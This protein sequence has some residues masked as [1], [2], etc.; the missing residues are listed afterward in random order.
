MPASRSS[1][2]DVLK[3]LPA[4]AFA[5]TAGA[6]AAKPRIRVGQIGTQHAHAA[7]KLDSILRFPEI[8][9]VVGVVEP[10]AERRA[11][12]Q[13]QAPYAGQTWLTEEELLSTE[14]LQ[15][16]AVETEVS[17]LVPTAMRCLTAGKHIHLDK[18]A[19]E[20]LDA[21]RAMHALAA[22]RGLTIQM[23]YMLR[24]NPAFVF[25]HQVV[26]DGW[27]GEITE[28]SGMMGKLINDKGRK[29]LAGFEG[30]GMFELACH[31]IDQVVAFLG[32]PSSV[33]A[34]THRT[35]PEKDR[36][37][38]NQLAVFDYPK[39]L[40]TIRCNHIDPMGGP[41]RQFNL[42]GTHG[43]LEIRPLEPTP[44]VRLGLDQARGDFKKGWQD[45]T[46]EP[47]SGRYDAEF[48]DLAAVLRGEKKLAWDAA[49]DLATHEAVLR[50]ADM[51][52]TA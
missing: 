35:Y 44:L 26:R 36:F 39:A 15:A 17:Q 43:T 2:R 12:L 45:V 19:G 20:S 16:V 50:A 11:L 47:P 41:R 14:G 21:C 37:A 3:I 34:F 40:A 52:P 18:P 42:T 31:L 28:I 24:Y 51:H 22:E 10:D 1:R 6:A 32:P 4:V 7:G 46:F 9:E 27:L 13:N 33:T 8:F 29:E 25:A 38:D 5:G 49:H 23:G 30:G 48:L